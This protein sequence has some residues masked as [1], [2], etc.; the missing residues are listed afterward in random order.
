MISIPN[1]LAICGSTPITANSPVPI[2]NDAIDSANRI[3][4][5]V[6]GETASKSGSLTA[7]PR[8]VAGASDNNVSCV[9]ACAVHGHG[10]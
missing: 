5:D 9:L 6:R 4:A 1:V 8:C 7:K 3:S 2:A 10:P